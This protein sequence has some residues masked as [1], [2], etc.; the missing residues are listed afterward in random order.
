MTFTINLTLSP[1]KNIYLSRH[2]ES[3]YNTE[4]RIGGDSDLSHKGLKYAKALP[5]ILPKILNEK[6]Q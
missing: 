2:G 3:L 5:K 1:Q 6:K 4:N